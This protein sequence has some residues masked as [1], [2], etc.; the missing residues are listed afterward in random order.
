MWPATAFSVALGNIQEKWSS[1]KFPP[2][3]LLF[4][5]EERFLI[6]DRD[7]SLQ[8][9]RFQCNDM[10]NLSVSSTVKSFTRFSVGFRATVHNLRP[11]IMKF[12]AV[13]MWF[14]I[15][16]WRPCWRILKQ[17]KRK[18]RKSVDMMRN[19]VKNSL[20]YSTFYYTF[21]HK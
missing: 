17:N 19:F 10:F 9:A 14:K 4:L 3:S 1:L 12:A 8:Y 13:H 5:L 2:T 15:Q 21:R 6:W 16:M 7:V 11:S 18:A 20:K